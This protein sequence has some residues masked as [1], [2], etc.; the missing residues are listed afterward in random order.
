MTTSGTTAPSAADPQSLRH[1]PEPP[2]SE[3]YDVAILGAGL[4]GSMLG[5]ILA[6][7]GVKTLVLDATT[8]PR[9]AIGESTIPYMAALV[10]MLSNRYDVPELAHLATFDGVNEN[11][12]RNSGIKRNFG[13]V[14]HREGRPQQPEESNQLVI[15]QVMAT[16]THLFRQDVDTYMFNVALKHGATGRTGVRI[17]DID[18]TDGVR[19]TSETGEV[20]HAE[21]L[22]DAGGYRSPVAEKLGLREEP[23]RARTHTRS[24]FTHM[25]GV[26]PYDATPSGSRQGQPS[27][28][29]NGTL[30]HVFDGGWL[31]VIPFDNHDESLNPLCS[32][33]LTLDPRVHPATGASPQEEFDG[34]LR[35][36][37]EI[38]AQFEDARPARPWTATGRLQYSSRQIVGDRFCL[39]SHAAGF[40]DPLYS[41]GMPNTLEVI[42]VL[43]WRLIEATK[44]GDWSTKRFQH[45]EDHQQGLFDVHD[46]LVFTSFVGFRDYD[47]WNAVFRTW[48]SSTV[49]AG[50]WLENLNER[51][52][53]TGDDSVYRDAEQT[54]YPG[55]PF[56][57]S[58]TFNAMRDITRTLCLEVEAGAITPTAAAD[59]IFALFAEADFIPPAFGFADRDDRFINL[60]PPKVFEAVRWAGTKAPAETGPLFVNSIKIRIMDRLKLVSMKE[61][62]V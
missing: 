4:A 13:F 28:W 7:N 15:P 49:V 8:H 48:A 12:S 61:G 58:D 43:A 1:D 60:T 37:P 40:I 32:V 51:F 52:T 16:E 38:A 59:R 50:V 9:F 57:V 42:N 22:V 41:R 6:R 25:I 44:D 19:L 46:D 11:I 23:T 14:Y 47:L 62:K 10:R 20:F 27:P 17:A 5:A 26:K 3:R 54:R 18:I 33:G 35:R 21:Y 36:F 39:T 24:L 30:H 29:H 45:V 2:G 53:L 55:S 34:F 31:W 56:P